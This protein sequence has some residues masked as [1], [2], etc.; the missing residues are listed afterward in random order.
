MPR[1]VF[2]VFTGPVEG[3]EDEYNDWYTNQHL[4]D[5]LRVPGIVSAERLEVVDMEPGRSLLP[6]YLALYEVE[7]DDV[8]NIPAAI[9]AAQASGEMPSSEAL[10]RASIRAA[11]YQPM[12]APAHV[13]S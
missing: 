4:Q 11:Y 5:V 9:A 7:T 3:R 12:P 13:R 6:R 1:Y 2:V 10:D 8:A